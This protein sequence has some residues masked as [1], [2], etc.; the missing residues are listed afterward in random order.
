VRPNGYSSEAARNGNSNGE[1]EVNS[2]PRIDGAAAW[3]D[4][5]LVIV[6]LLIIWQ[7]LGSL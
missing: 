3:L 2:E 7:F 5:E 6:V 4:V 1:L